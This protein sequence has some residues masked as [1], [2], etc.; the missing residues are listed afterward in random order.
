MRA[1]NLT[2]L[3]LGALRKICPA[4]AACGRSRRISG[5]A[6]ITVNI[7]FGLGLRQFGLILY[8]FLFGGLLKLNILWL[9][10]AT[11]QTGFL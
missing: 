11:A 6:V 8:E 7:G 9:R 4:L 3:A 2:S 1:H 10:K 5:T